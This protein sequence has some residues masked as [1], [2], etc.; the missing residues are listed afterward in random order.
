[1]KE[2]CPGHE[3]FGHPCFDAVSH[4]SVGRIHL[5]VAPRCNI[6]CNYCSRKHDCANENRPGVTTRVIGPTAALERVRQAVELEPRIKVV[7]IAGPGD[8]LANEA[9]FET[10]RLVR[11]EFPHMSLCLSTNGLL[12]SHKLDELVA[13]GLNS[14]TVTV[15]TLSEATGAAIYAYVAQG[16]QVLRGREGAAALRDS[17][18]EGIGRAT[19]LGI[20]VKVNSVLLPGLNEEEMPVM[21]RRFKDMGVAVMN[22]MPLNPQADF[23]HHEPVSAETH[24][25]IRRQ[26]S[27]MLEQVS[28]CRQCRADAAGLLG[29][30]LLLAS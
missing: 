29:R 5:P 22:I 27:Q 2:N 14:L 12:L 21:A 17:Q 9:T 13:L 26:C 11:R 25:R 23:A 10:L 16:G 28:H 15:N 8:P 4:G 30:D 24:Q 18:M 19:E 1:M 20:R 6:K 7:G 3:P